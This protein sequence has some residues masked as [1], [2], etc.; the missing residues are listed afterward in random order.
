MQQEENP[1]EDDS[2]DFWSYHLPGFAQV[3]DCSISR[4]IFPSPDIPS[5]TK[6]LP[7][8]IISNY[9]QVLLYTWISVALNNPLLGI[10]TLCSFNYSPHLRKE[11]PISSWSAQTSLFCTAAPAPAP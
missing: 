5:E 7:A 9:S 4:R 6:M 8:T 10:G 11:A 2:Q 3:P 1:I